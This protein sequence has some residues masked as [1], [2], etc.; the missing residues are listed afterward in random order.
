[1][2]LKSLLLLISS[3]VVL[4]APANDK[5]QIII[6][7]SCDKKLEVG[8]Q[9]NDVARGTIIQIEAGKSH[10]LPVASNWAGRVWAREDCKV[11]DC[12]IAGASNP[13]SLAEFKLS[14]NKDIDY[15]DVSLVDGY[16]LP[17]QIEPQMINGLDSLVKLDPKHCRISECTN[18]PKCPKDLQAVDAQGKFVACNSACSKYQTDEFCCTGSHSTA[19]T[20]TTNHYA[21]T[22]KN[23][24]PNS[25]SYAFDDATSVYG[26][27]ANAYQIVFCPK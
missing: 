23:A 10:T 21:S 18:L 20:C 2:T 8:Y 5:K 27:K 11:H 12:D 17:M 26:C 19:D 6:L 22:V 16:N 9:T 13:A 14:S 25:Y 1:M 3:A 24:C 7:N 15:Y 4:A